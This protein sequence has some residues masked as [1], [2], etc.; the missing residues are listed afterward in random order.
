[1]PPAATALQQS[2]TRWTK[3]SPAWVMQP[4]TALPAHDGGWAIPSL[5]RETVA[6][7]PRGTAATPFK[8]WRRVG[9]ATRR[10]RASNRTLSMGISVHD[11]DYV[12][13]IRITYTCRKS[14][15]ASY[16]GCNSRLEFLV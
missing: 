15:Q 16:L 7:I 1:M 8:I 4:V 12:H 5:G 10:A 11:R 2:L 14:D 9:E 6:P 13:N 3:L